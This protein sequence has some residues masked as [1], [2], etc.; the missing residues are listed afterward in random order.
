MQRRER[1]GCD[2]VWVNIIGRCYTNG[3]VAGTR[4]TEGVPCRPRLLL[5]GLLV[6]LCGVG[7]WHRL[8]AWCLHRLDGVLGH[9]V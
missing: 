3:L 6:R 8:Q 9:G 5:C 4:R 2:V 7:Q 1:K